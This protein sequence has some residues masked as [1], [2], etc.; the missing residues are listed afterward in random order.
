MRKDEVGNSAR[1]YLSPIAT[2]VG[3]GSSNKYWG[4]QPFGGKQVGNIGTH[5]IKVL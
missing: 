4:S 2:T 3:T 5:D 1:R